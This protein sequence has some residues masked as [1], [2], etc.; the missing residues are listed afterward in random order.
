[1]NFL[2][3]NAVMLSSNSVAG[4][5]V[6]TV[7][8]TMSDGS[9]FSGTLIFNGITGPA[10]SS[11]PLDSPTPGFYPN[12]AVTL[13]NLNAQYAALS[14]TLQAEYNGIVGTDPTDFS[15]MGIGLQNKINLVNLLTVFGGLAPNLQ[16]QYNATVSTNS[17]TYN[18]TPAGIVAKL[19]LIKSYFV[20][21]AGAPT[22]YAPDFTP[23]LDN[24]TAQY[25]A[26]SPTLQAEY[27]GIVGGDNADFNNTSG[28]QNKANLVALLTSY[29]N[30]SLGL[31]TL[32]D[33][34][35]GS[36]PGTYNNTPSG[37]LNKLAL[38]QGFYTPPPWAATAGNYLA[39]SGNNLVLVRNLVAANDDG[40]SGFT[41]TATQNGGQASGS[42][43]VT[44]S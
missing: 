1:V 31:S 27:N 11:A 15:N 25:N 10:A 12:P 32:F 28:L 40:T 23:T 7:Q 8:V 36:N 30:L 29:S 3:A 4:T 35:V 14:A 19:G 24:I 17:G 21:P 6:A 5:L 43:S 13:D 42:L 37:I 18:N 2:P 44:V 20:P 9:A 16:A 38:I 22:T 33:S 39:F 34:T 26:L 41:I